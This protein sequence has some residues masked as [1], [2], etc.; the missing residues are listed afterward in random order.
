MKKHFSFLAVLSVLCCLPV[1]GQQTFAELEQLTVNEHVTTLV[2]ASEPVR[3][4]DISTD[5]VFADKPIDNTVRLRPVDGDHEDGDVV[6]IV[7]IVTERYRTQYALVYTT[8]LEEAVSDKEILPS[9]CILYNN[10]SVSMS[11]E[12]MSRYARRIWNSPAKYRNVKTHQ[13]R[14]M[15]RLN[16]IYSCG[17][18]FFIDFTVLNRSRLKFDI[19]DI[20]FTLSDKKIAKATNQQVVSLQPV[21]LL[22]KSQSFRSAYR[23][24]VVIKKMTFPNDKVLTVEL[25]ERQIS[26][27]TISMTIDYEDVLSADA[28]SRLLQ[29]ED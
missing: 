14:L 10:P 9:E 19:D 7:T 5:G 15:M 8:R 29:E 11:T 12:E 25:S 26:G 17:D 2:T 23:N 6:A 1:S 18:Y 4:V 20:R 13:H 28:F 24:V 21:F 3:L 22:D 16:N 27:R